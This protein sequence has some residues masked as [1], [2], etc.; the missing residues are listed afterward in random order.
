LNERP[1]GESIYCADTQLKS[2]SDQVSRIF[3]AALL[4]FGMATALLLARQLEV[5]HLGIGPAMNADIV[6]ANNRLV[7]MRELIANGAGVATTANTNDQ[8]EILSLA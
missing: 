5:A 7:S 1:A 8:T 4:T 2:K 3:R 6:I